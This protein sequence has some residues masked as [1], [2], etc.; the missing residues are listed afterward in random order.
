MCLV[1]K[2]IPQE[3]WKNFVWPHKL[4]DIHFSSSVEYSLGYIKYHLKDDFRYVLY[5]LEMF[6]LNIYFQK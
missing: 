5:L 6:L 1:D 2:K 4:L 3:R